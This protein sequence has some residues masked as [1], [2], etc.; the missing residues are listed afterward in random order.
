MFATTTGSPNGPTT[1][2]KYD[3]VEATVSLFD[4]IMG[5]F[6]SLQAEEEPTSSSSAASTEGICQQQHQRT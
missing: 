2:T 6:E 4:M 1:A 3:D 5:E